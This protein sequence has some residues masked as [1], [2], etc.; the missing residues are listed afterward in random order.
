M[1][2]IIVQLSTVTKVSMRVIATK[3]MCI[4]PYQ[5]YKYKVQAI[6]GRGM[7]TEVM[8]LSVWEKSLRILKYK[9]QLTSV[10]KETQ[11]SSKILSAS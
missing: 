5:E 9:R 1:L 10:K 7:R 4:E 8:I 6:E 2:K 11:R 3:E